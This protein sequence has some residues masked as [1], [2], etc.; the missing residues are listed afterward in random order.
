MRTSLGSGAKL[1]HE[2]L[3]LG[4]GDALLQDL[5]RAD[6]IAG[7]EGAGVEPQPWKDLALI[8]AVRS[9]FKTLVVSGDQVKPIDLP[10]LHAPDDVLLYA[11]AAEHAQLGP[12]SKLTLLAAISAASSGAPRM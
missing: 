11:I 9:G 5:M 6:E 4:A 10:I 2:A 12:R 1:L 3:M 8:N 7:D